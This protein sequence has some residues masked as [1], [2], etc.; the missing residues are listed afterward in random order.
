[1]AVASHVLA[2]GAAIGA[3]SL[4][5]AVVSQARATTG[6]P[7]RAREV[8]DL[9][10][11]ASIVG[12]GLLAADASR[13]ERQLGIVDSGGD[14]W[15]Y[16]GSHCFRWAGGRTGLGFAV[17]G[18]VLAG[19]AVIDAMAD[20]FARGEAPFRQLLMA[21]L[22]EGV[23]AGG[24]ARGPQSAVLE[25][26]WPTALGEEHLDLRV[27][28]SLDPLAELMRLEALYGHYGDTSTAGELV[29]MDRTIVE[30]VQAGLHRLGMAPDDQRFVRMS[31]APSP[32]PAL[33]GVGEPEELRGPWT[34]AWQ[35]ALIDWMEVENL[36]LRVTA[37][38]WIDPR[39]LQ[40]LRPRDR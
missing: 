9:G 14:A 16:T 23:V 10:V 40:R 29:R 27:D 4:K 20:R 18:N 35:Q 22:A 19:P 5:G 13:S 3:V 34:P 7:R 32:A 33:P 8:L 15:T 36:E 6:S 28:D 24:D 1:M 21:C 30:Q 38:G 17:Q 25:V 2:C 31:S 39:V 11:T 12:E 26:A 37:S